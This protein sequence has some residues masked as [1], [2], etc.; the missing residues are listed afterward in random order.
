MG[1][2]HGRKWLHLWAVL[3]HHYMLHVA[4]EMI[5]SQSTNVCLL[6]F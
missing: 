1:P 6:R 4:I 2:K 3:F 5:N